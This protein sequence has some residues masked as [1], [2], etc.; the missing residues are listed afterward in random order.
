MD[1]VIE[2]MRE[3]LR[4]YE[5]DKQEDRDTKAIKSIKKAIKELEK[6]YK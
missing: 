1:H 4:V 3:W 2:S 6:F 5:D